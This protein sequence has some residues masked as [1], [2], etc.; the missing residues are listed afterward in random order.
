MTQTKASCSKCKKTW[1]LITFDDETA[2][3]WLY[4][5]GWRKDEDGNWYCTECRGDLK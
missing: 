5:A 1:N 2:T 4:R 3:A